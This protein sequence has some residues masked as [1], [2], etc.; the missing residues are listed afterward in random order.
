MVPWPGFRRA[1]TVSSKPLWAMLLTSSSFSVSKGH[2]RI[3]WWRDSMPRPFA[4]AAARPSKNLVLKVTVGTLR[5]SSSIE[6]WIH[7]AV[8]DPQL[9]RPV[10]TASALEA[11]SSNSSGVRGTPG[12]VSLVTMSLISCFS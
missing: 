2:G 10:I 8:Q 7:H 5:F 6:S 11:R 1:L 9:P 4:E 3:P 12:R